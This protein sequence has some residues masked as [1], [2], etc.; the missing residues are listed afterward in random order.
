MI[1]ASKVQE[2]IGIP[3]G[4]NGVSESASKIAKPA[5][6]QDLRSESLGQSSP[7]N[8]AGTAAS[9]PQADGSPIACAPSAPASVKRFQKINTP[10]PV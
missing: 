1:M 9:K 4:T 8:A 7:R 5:N 3:A 2:I 6:T 10:K